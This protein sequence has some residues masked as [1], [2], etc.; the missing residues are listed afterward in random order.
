MEKNY[1]AILINK[2]IFFCQSKIDNPQTSEAEKDA[3]KFYIKELKEIS[4]CPDSQKFRKPH[5]RIGG[6]GDEEIIKSYVIRDNNNEPITFS[7]GKLYTVKCTFKNVSTYIHYIQNGK[8][9]KFSPQNGI[10][11]L[12][13][14][15]I[16]GIKQYT[17]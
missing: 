9:A 10:Q 6:Y 17:R 7:N 13:P 4:P 5:M 8:Q 3:M 1:E 16:L 2:A 15:D 12:N 14:Y 11:L